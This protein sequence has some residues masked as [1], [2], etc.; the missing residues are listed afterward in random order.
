MPPSGGRTEPSRGTPASRDATP[1]SLGGTPASTPPHAAIGSYRHPT[2]SS[3]ESVVHASPSSQCIAL[4]ATH[5]PPLQVSRPL[6]TELSAHA[7]PSG[8]LRSVGQTPEEP[9]QRS[10]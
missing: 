3:H 8:A 4:P 5:D 10:V 1:P 2:L 9:V 7:V 6:Q